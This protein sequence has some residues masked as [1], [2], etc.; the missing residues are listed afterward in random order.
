MAWNISKAKRQALVKLQLRDKEGK[1]IEMGGGVKWYSSRLKKVV[2]GTVVGTKGANALV[3][4]N[5]EN[6]THEP[7][8][9]TVPAASITAI[10]GKASL[11]PKGSNKPSA[12]QTPEFE[13]PEAVADVEADPNAEAD[14]D[15]MDQLK[16]PQHLAANYGVTETSDGNTYITRKDGESIYSPARGLK[17]GDELIAPAGADPTKPFSIGRGWATKGTERLNKEGEGPVIGKVI[18]VS[19]NRYAVVQMAGG[20][21]I[22]DR[23]NPEEQTDTVT[24]GL[25]NQVILATMGLKDA[26]GDRVSSQTYAERPSDE[27]KEVAPDAPEAQ[28][29][30]EGREVPEDQLEAEEQAA[31]TDRAQVLKDMPV[32]GRIQTEDESQVFEKRTDNQWA[33]VSGNGDLIDDNSVLGMV[34]R[35]EADGK[36]WQAFVPEDSDSAPESAPEQE[37]AP[38]ASPAPESPAEEAPEAVE[39]APETEAPA[40]EAPEESAGVKATPVNDIVDGLAELEQAA[41]DVE[42]ANL[43]GEEADEVLDGATFKVTAADGKTYE[44]SA[45]ADENG[46]WNFRVADENGDEVASHIIGSEE[47]RVLAERI[48]NPAGAKKAEEAPAAEAIPEA[49]PESTPETP[50]AES[51]NEN[52]LTEAEQRELTGYT[53]L[54]SRSYE[55][56][57]DE[58]GDRYKALAD[59]LLAR[60]EERKASAPAEQPEKAPESAPQAE[61][62][63]EVTPEPEEAPE[64]A[65]APSLVE[66]DSSP[67]EVSAQ[68]DQDY[69]GSASSLPVG[70]KIYSPDRMVEMSKVGQ[71]QWTLDSRNGEL[72]DDATVDGMVRRNQSV[73]GETYRQSVPG[74]SNDSSES[75]PNEIPEGGSE[76]NKPALN[77]EEGFTP[78]DGRGLKDKESAEADSAGPFG[79]SYEY[80]NGLDHPVASNPEAM[81]DE[82]NAEF[83]RQDIALSHAQHNNRRGAETIARGKLAELE[84]RVQSRLD[85]ESLKDAR[86]I[87]NGDSLEEPTSESNEPETAPSET[88]EDP[89]VEA[90]AAEAP[91]AA[92]VVDPNANEDGLLPDEAARL[93]D[94]ENRQAAAFRG[95]SNEDPASFDAE[96]SELI[97]HGRLRG[98]GR[99]VGPFVARNP[100]PD[101]APAQDSQDSQDSQPAPETNA[102]EAPE[103]PA[104]EAPR[105]RRARGEVVP[106]ADADGNMITRGDKIGHPTLGPVEITNTIPGSGR[107]EF[108]DPTTGRKKS[109]KAA[110]VRKIDPNAAEAAP[111]EQSATVEPGTRFVDAATGKQGFGDKNGSRVLVGDRVRH[112]NGTTGTVKSVYTAGN[113]GAWP[114]ILWDEDRKVRRAMGNVLEKDDSSAPETTPEPIEVVRPSATPSPAPERVEP[115]EEPFEPVRPSATPVPE[116]MPEPAPEVAPE[117]ETHEAALARRQAMVDATPVNS[118]I[119]SQDGSQKFYRVDESTW[120]FN[121]GSLLPSTNVV[122][123]IGLGERRGQ[124]YEIA[125]GRPAQNNLPESSTPAVDAPLPPQT[126]QAPEEIAP[127]PPV[128]IAPAERER[129]ISMLRRLPAGTT[130]KPRSGQY[131]LTKNGSDDWSSTVDDGV[132]DTEDIYDIIDRGRRSGLLYEVVRPN[133]GQPAPTPAPEPEVSLEANS[134]V[135]PTV[136]SRLEAFRRAPIG[137]TVTSPGGTSTYTKV[138]ADEWTNPDISGATIKNST[139]SIATDSDNGY[140]VFNKTGPAEPEGTNITAM[141]ATDRLAAFRQAPIGSKLVSTGGK[142]IT[143]T[144]DRK[145]VSD[146]GTEYSP[147]DLVFVTD[148]RQADVSGPFGLVLPETGTPMDVSS[149]GGTLPTNRSERHSAIARLPLGSKITVRRFTF[150]KIGEN[151]WT[152]AEEGDNDR[153]TDLDVARSGSESAPGV[154]ILP[155]P[156]PIPQDLASRVRV[157]EEAPIG[158]LVTSS[159]GESYTKI[160]DTQWA[161][162]ATLRSFKYGLGEFATKLVNNPYTGNYFVQGFDVPDPTPFAGGEM[163]PDSAELER[164]L[165][166]LP[167][168]ATVTGGRNNTTFVRRGDD[169]WSPENAPEEYYNDADLAWRLSTSYS[170]NTPVADIPSTEPDE[171]PRERIPMP[172]EPFA[173]LTFIQ[174]LPVGGRVYHEGTGETFEKTGTD[175]WKNTATGATGLSNAQVYLAAKTIDGWYSNRPNEPEAPARPVIHD[176]LPKGS[177]VPNAAGSKSGLKKVEKDKWEMIKDGQPTGRFVNDEAAAVLQELV[178]TDVFNPRFGENVGMYAEDLKLPGGKS[179]GEYLESGGS[180]GRLSEAQ[181]QAIRRGYERFIENLNTKLPEGYTAKLEYLKFGSDPDGMHSSVEFYDRNGRALGPA[182]RRFGTAVDD[183]TGRRVS[184]VDHAYWD[185]AKRVQGSGI[186]AAFL[187]AS[188]QMYRQMGLDRI[189]VHA[190]ISV[191]SYAWARGGF[192]FQS[193]AH[194]SRA[195]GAWDGSWGRA[196]AGREQEWADGIAEFNRLKALA[197]PEAFMNKT[198]PAAVVFANIGRPEDPA[199]A[200]PNDKWFGK[201]ML[202]NTH[203]WG[204]FMLNPRG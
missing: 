136:A 193:R 92:P 97:R 147:A 32:G 168:G 17:V 194:M 117:A 179:L 66:P 118:M 187:E 185:L 20:H 130:I 46:D 143:K 152:E 113:G 70:S 190:D 102:P 59:E 73:S 178:G 35:G 25:S 120:Q 10:E 83:R 182:S 191:G 11:A 27:E 198:H 161:D 170:I 192:D 180:Y 15:H 26:L 38:E 91:Q 22:A 166:E 149:T 188:K 115:V 56:F 36:K 146:A 177:F 61:E 42:S 150:T 176:T 196:P 145:W 33:Y 125:E 74:S 183:R 172:D 98:R 48:A 76:G 16:G 195:M 6:P 30:H 79:I 72:I 71:N 204:E 44:V 138:A 84:R 186:S 21:T 53:R 155:E 9:V 55:Q 28:S 114:A 12:D 5:K 7:A 60:G 157:S 160:S 23:R 3:R 39:E 131:T 95:E 104:E 127:E 67:E 94:L 1:F 134:L 52:G 153:Y 123:M 101:P 64:A 86:D 111:E 121:E 63:P 51:Y 181:K 43:S 154:V 135:P 139:L 105:A 89:A 175:Q 199:K 57:K 29:D 137:T 69:A 165:R 47:N 40:E 116:A 100:A 82:E 119:T 37:E 144:E 49:A 106:V 122:A 99:E 45:G 151:H 87:Q 126:P 34:Q 103:T 8:L 159:S 77:G 24:V 184:S 13:K 124:S 14:S 96:I 41:E 68:A 169:V 128:E 174:D 148:P 31:P 129:R 142:V 78:V 158:T 202:S 163:S 201:V 133:S 50:E 189:T 107:V 156:K 140:W 19:E 109:V 203:W 58:E 18:A 200:G 162:T 132:Y 167:E 81:N 93:A 65:P 90:P 4:L 2:A 173:R 85:S 164:Q 54:A 80:R 62:T 110:R 75:D 108:I 171:A 112:A 88:A 197:T 141:T